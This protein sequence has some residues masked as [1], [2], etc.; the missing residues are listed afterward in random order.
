M[1][2]NTDE[3][4]IQNGV[5][6][7]IYFGTLLGYARHKCIIPW[8]DDVDIIIP[9]D[10]EQIFLNLN[11]NNYGLKIIKLPSEEG[12]FFYKIIQMNDPKKNPFPFIDVFFYKTENNQTIITAFGNGKIILATDFTTFRDTFNGIDVNIIKKYKIHLNNFYKDW[13]KIVKSSSWN[14]KL[15]KSISNVE[16]NPIYSFKN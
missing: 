7:T 5:N 16:I 6:Y 15:E 8:D 12:K 14:H 10:Q 3:I 1:L 9:Y 11:F 2:K 4:L 13:K